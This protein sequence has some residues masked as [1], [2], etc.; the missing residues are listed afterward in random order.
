M[1]RKKLF[2]IVR[3]PPIPPAPP[4][5]SNDARADR[6]GKINYQSCVHL[7]W[8]LCLSAMILLARSLSHASD[9][10]CIERDPPAAE[11]ILATSNLEEI[12]GGTG[13]LLPLSWFEAF[14]ARAQGNVAKA[15]EAFAAA[16]EKPEAKLLDH[17]DD[18]VL[19]AQLGLID[20]GLHCK[21]EAIAEVCAWSSYDRFRVM[22]ST[23]RLFFRVLAMIYA[24]VGDVDPAI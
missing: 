20:A 13:S 19:V 18:G 3:S 9:L 6:I 21:Q 11:K 4:M 17:P 14:I 7:D 2:S 16:R 5:L 22:P 24:W 15:R 1:T 10:L 23:A 8:I 12:V